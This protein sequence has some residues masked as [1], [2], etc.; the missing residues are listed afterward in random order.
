MTKKCISSTKKMPAINKKKCQSSTKQMPAIDQNNLTYRSKKKFMLSTLKMP[1]ITKQKKSHQSKNC[2]TSTQKMH[3]KHANHRSETKYSSYRIR[4]IPFFLGN[5]LKKSLEYILKFFFYSKVQFFRLIM[6]NNFIQISA[7]A[8]DAVA[9]TWTDQFLS[10]LSIV[11]HE[12]CPCRRNI[13][14]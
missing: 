9:Y 5:A 6:E 2:I 1:V 10:T 12:Y 7:S 11:C 14:L 8:G 13:Y 4:Q 3:Q